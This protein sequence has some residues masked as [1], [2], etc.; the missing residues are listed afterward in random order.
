MLTDID[1]K[2]ATC[3][4]GKTRHRLTDGEGLYLEVSPSGTKRWFWKFYPNGKESRMALGPYG[5]GSGE[6]TLKA[7]RA[8]R[9]DARKLHKSGAN[10]VQARSAERILKRASASVTFQAVAEEFHTK[11]APGWSDSHAKQWLRCCQKDLFPRIGTLPLRDV[12]APVLLD[13]LRRVEARGATQLVRDLREFAGQVFKYG[14]Q[15]GKCDGNPARDLVGAFKPHVV[16]HAAALLTPSAIGGLLRAIDCYQ[17]QPTTKA[18]LLL[19]ALIFQRPGNIRQLEWTWIDL[20][21]A[22][23][24]I[25]SANMKRKKDAKVNGRPHLVPLCT[26]ALAVLRDIHP[27]SGHGR[28]VFPSIRTGLKP[29]SENTVNAALRG[30]GYDSDEMS[31]QGFRAMARTVLRENVKGI[32]PEVIEAQLAH[33]KSG[34]L[35][36]AYDRAEYMVFRGELMQTWANYLDGLRQGADIVPIKGI[37]AAA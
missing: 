29:M 31:A 23:L 14:I 25:P 6:L 32:D 3:P 13:A 26:Q 37:E 11:Q 24:T 36:G 7:A 12:S 8:A 20:E 34:P 5:K 15:T 4:E 2:N 27:I 9:D 10:P 28:Y 30:M 33:E 1:C 17:G 19:S 21:T 18:A 35:G 22:V 16:K